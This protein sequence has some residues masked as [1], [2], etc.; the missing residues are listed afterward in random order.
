MEIFALEALVK[1]NQDM[2]DAL[3]TKL[4]DQRYQ[5]EEAHMSK[6]MGLTDDEERKKLAERVQ[7]L[8][9]MRQVLDEIESKISLLDEAEAERETEDTEFGRLKARYNTLVRD[10]TTRLSTDALSDNR[11]SELSLKV[12]TLMTTAEDELEKLMED[13][14]KYDLLDCDVDVLAEI[15]STIT[16]HVAAGS[17][18]D[19][20]QDTTTNLSSTSQ[21][22]LCAIVLQIIRDANG[23]IPLASLKEKIGQAAREQGLQESQGVSAVYMLVANRLISID[24]LQKDNPVRAD[25]WITNTP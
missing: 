21:I 17:Y 3:D 13:R 14:R 8:E 2:N 16:D 20:N 5:A 15:N 18:P 24:R 19:I 11:T 23:I 4:Y 6:Q 1:E 22:I 10:N 12:H 9:T 7:E 25:M